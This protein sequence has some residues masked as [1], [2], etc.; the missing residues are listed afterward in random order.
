MSPEAQIDV[1]RELDG[2]VAEQEPLHW[3]VPLFVMAQAFGEETHGWPIFATQAEITSIVTSRKV[4][5][6]PGPEHW[7]L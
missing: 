6:P 7:R 5:I 2:V 4:V 1:Q 3:V